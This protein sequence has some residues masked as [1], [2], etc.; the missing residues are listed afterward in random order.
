MERVGG[1]SG[2]QRERVEGTQRRLVL[3]LEVG[4]VYQRAVEC[5]MQECRDEGRWT[6]ERD[7]KSDFV[8]RARSYGGGDTGGVKGVGSW[9]FS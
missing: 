2:V 1:G 8:G 3:E 7:S 4:K 9:R 6:F 5:A